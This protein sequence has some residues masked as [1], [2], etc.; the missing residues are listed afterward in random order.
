MT[1]AIIHMPPNG[2]S[3]DTPSAPWACIDRQTASCT[4]FGVRALMAA[5]FFRVRR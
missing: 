5:M 1:G 2:I 3:L 4:T